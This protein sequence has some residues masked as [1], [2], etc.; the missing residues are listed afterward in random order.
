MT[1]KHNAVR[2]LVVAAAFLFCGTEAIAQE[3]QNG[4]SYRDVPSRGYFR[5]NYENDVFFRTDKYYTQGVHF[6]LLDA[7]FSNSVI[8]YLFPRLK[9]TPRRCGIGL[10]SAGYSP[11][12]IVADSILRGDHPFAGLAYAKLFSIAVDTVRK[13]RIT[14]TL[15]LGWMGPSAGGYEIQS[16]IHKAVGSP[17]PLGWKYQLKDQPVINYELNAERQIGL[18]PRWLRFS[19]WAML[20]AGTLSNRAAAGIIL[21]AV[22]MRKGRQW[23]DAYLHPAVSFSAYEAVLQGGPFTRGNPYR[24]EAGDLKRVVG[25][26]IGGVNLR[27]GRISIGAYA[28]WETAAFRGA[29]DHALGG[30]TFATAF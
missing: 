23:L 10:E 9:H 20:R 4:L 21:N 14:G 22:G 28:R 6:E 3:I 27:A 2:L 15:S 29:T 26:V 30:I 19:A 17:E 7:A 5:F 11:T 12:S 8:S 16:A 18:R 25:S 13:R 24:I 1:S